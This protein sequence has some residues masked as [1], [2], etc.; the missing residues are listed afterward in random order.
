LC[1]VF[2]LPVWAKLVQAK[3][4][5]LPKWARGENY[6]SGV[7]PVWASIEPLNKGGFRIHHGLGFWL[8]LIVPINLLLYNNKI[9]CNLKAFTL[10]NN[11]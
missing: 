8:F 2:A 9:K 1:L 11:S 6:K 3:S 4:G 10:F 5:L 7:L